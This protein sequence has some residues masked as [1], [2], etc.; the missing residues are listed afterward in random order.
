MIEKWR[1][2][3][4]VHCQHLVE[5]IVILA[6]VSC[7]DRGNGAKRHQSAKESCD[8][9]AGQDIRDQFEEK[10]KKFIED[11]NLG[12]PVVDPKVAF[13]ERKGAQVQERSATG[14]AK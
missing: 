9:Q 12:N 6:L 3:I 11:N 5:V 8:G 2:K 14:E 10:R 13:P 1:D 4:K 7:S